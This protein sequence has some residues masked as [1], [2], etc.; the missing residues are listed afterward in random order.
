MSWHETD[1]FRL[2]DGMVV[3]EWFGGDVTNMLYQVGAYTPPWL[4]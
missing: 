4:S 3:E 1:V 2:V